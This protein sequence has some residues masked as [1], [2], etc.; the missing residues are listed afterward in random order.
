MA[1][2]QG[3]K[4]EIQFD[5]ESGRMT[6]RQIGK[7]WNMS[8][9]TLKKFAVEEDWILGRYDAELSQRIE[10]SASDSLVR[11][12]SQK[13]VEMAEDHLK[14][15][16]VIDGTYK[17]LL[18]FHIMELKESEGLMSKADSDKWKANYQALEVV[19]N[20][21]DKSFR[22]KRLAMGLKETEG[23]KMNMNVFLNKSKDYSSLSDKQLDIIIADEE[24][25][26]QSGSN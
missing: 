17:L 15:I 1:Y 22:S 2:N 25:F 13:L 4:K 3:Q 5:Y 16:G 24:K 23:P 19:L 8:R 14:N 12:E 10:E 18:E 26:E 20:A 9:Q 11:R 7:K 21:F 6:T